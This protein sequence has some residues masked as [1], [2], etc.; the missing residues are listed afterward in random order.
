MDSGREEEGSEECSSRKGS[1][2]MKSRQRKC[3]VCMSFMQTG[4][5]QTQSTT[6]LTVTI[7][8]THHSWAP[9]EA[10]WLRWE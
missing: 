3:A 7:C 6:T 1:G 2:K 8:H 4:G 9:V 10:G 5:K